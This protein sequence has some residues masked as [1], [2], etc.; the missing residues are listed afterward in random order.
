MEWNDKK[1]QQTFRCG[2]FA[3]CAR[4]SQSDIPLSRTSMIWVIHF[5]LHLYPSL[6]PKTTAASTSFTHETVI[7]KI[8]S[9][10]HR[11]ISFDA[12][13][14][15][16][17]MV[18]GFSFMLINV[19]RS[20]RTVWIMYMLSHF[21]V[22]GLATLCAWWEWLL[23]VTS[24]YIL[25]AYACARARAITSCRKSLEEWRTSALLH[26]KSKGKMNILLWKLL[27]SLVMSFHFILKCSF[28]IKR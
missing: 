28:Y 17:L 9:F 14:Y 27:S 23:Q 2:W 24:L 16:S 7:A 26:S 8:C 25:C 21:G 12:R 13:V 20:K 5:L 22:I 11:I 1:F 19:S 6:E 4:R 10:S 18:W 3:P 15:S